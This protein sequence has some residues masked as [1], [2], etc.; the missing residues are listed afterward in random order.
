VG[1]NLD[2]QQIPYRQLQPPLTLH[3]K[4]VRNVDRRY[5][6]DSMKMTLFLL[7]RYIHFQ[8]LRWFTS[9]LSL[10]KNEG[11]ALTIVVIEKAS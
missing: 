11:L 9:S 2:F 1:I 5:T 3:Y 4:T 10:Y 6:L 8:F 7:Y